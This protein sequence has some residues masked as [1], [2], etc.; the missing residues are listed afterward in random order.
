MNNPISI[1]H[2]S[3]LHKDKDGN[4][5]NLMESLK[6]DCE[7]YLN[8]IQKPNIVVLSGDVIKGG[9]DEEIIDQYSESS[10]FLEEVVDYFLDGDKSRIIIVPGNHDIDWNVSIASMERIE[11]DDGRNLASTVENFF[12][13]NSNFRWSW[14]N[15]SFFLIKEKCKYNDRL[16]HFINFYNSFYDELRVYTKDTDKQYQIYDLPEFGVA[17]IGFNSCFDN[18]HL[19]HSGKINPTCIT[20][21]SGELKDLKD[22]GRLIIG[23]WHHHTA[24]QPN[25]S[26]YLDNRI[27]SAMIDRNINIGL[28][29]HQ[30][31]CGAINEF[32]SVF[33]EK[34][35]T[36]FSAGTLYGNR[37]QLPFGTSRQYNIIE[38]KP[39]DDFQYK[40]TIHSREDV[41]SNL[42]EI[43]S[44]NKGRINKT[45]NSSWTTYIDEPKQPETEKILNEIMLDFEN[46][47]DILTAI[48]RLRVMNQNNRL[49][50]KVLVDY[51]EISQ[52]SNLICDLLREPKNNRE[53][54]IIMNSALDI[55]DKTLLNMLLDL[56][57]IKES[58]DP[59][60]IKMRE[61][62]K[63]SI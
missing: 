40:V 16:N 11:I 18:D 46:S 45:H 22:K 50:R 13:D 53:S 30:H 15:L 20:N 14:S 39:N 43:P 7:S 42:F 59:S 27:L 51:L 26:N 36:L 34:K 47:G 49:V 38:I 9:T 12:W 41:D 3:D 61:S 58:Q 44:W 1:L 52:D 25:E 35:I 4:F 57:I 6:S 48:E 63:I 56:P 23:V 54:I 5:C 2:I 29:G 33:D 37:S 55:D 24:G 10:V 32:K 21:A 8:E 62:I 60:L 28:H 19:N 17:F 31:I